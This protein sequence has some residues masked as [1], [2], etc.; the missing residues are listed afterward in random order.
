MQGAGK[1]GQFL[2]RLDQGLVGNAESTHVDRPKGKAPLALFH[3][4]GRYCNTMK[5]YNNITCDEYA[6]PLVHLVKVGN[7]HIKGV[8]KKLLEIFVKL[9]SNVATWGR[10]PASTTNDN[11]EPQKQ[12]YAAQKEVKQSQQREGTEPNLH[13]WPLFGGLW[14]LDFFLMARRQQRPRPKQSPLRTGLSEIEFKASG[15]LPGTLEHRQPPQY[16]P[17]RIGTRK[18][19]EGDPMCGWEVGK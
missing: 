2:G 19:E 9:R 15:I 4:Y 10:S 11:E 14:C 13:A 6:Q 1:G 12:N 7:E 8:P 18:H 3:M 17:S 16:G 5:P